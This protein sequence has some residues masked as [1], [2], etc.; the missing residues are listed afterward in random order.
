MSYPDHPPTNGN[1][2]GAY[3]VVLSGEQDRS[4]VTELSMTLAR[5]ISAG[6]PEV[7][8]DMSTVEFVD[9]AA[10]RVIARADQFLR[11]RSRTLT[12][13]SP[14]NCVE[15][16]LTLCGLEAL[17]ET[18]AGRRARGAGALSSWVAVPAAAPIP[19]GGAREPESGGV[20]VS[21]LLRTLDTST[22]GL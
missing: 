6:N 10:V 20:S 17:I 15:Q 9:A 12:V 3:L 4:T 7:V 8:V 2:L 11:R 14:S 13:R 16:L 5:A 21:E 19:Q 1:T 22:L 18:L